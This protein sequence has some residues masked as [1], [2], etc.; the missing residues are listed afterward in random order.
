MDMGLPCGCTRR[1]RGRGYEYEHL[2]PF[3][4]LR[5]AYLA[6]LPYYP[7]SNNISSWMPRRYCISSLPHECGVVRRLRFGSGSGSGAGVDDG[8]GDGRE[9]VA[10]CYVVQ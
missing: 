7:S 3:V 4:Q 1:G 6:Y 2:P 8:D 10:W 5:V 9:E